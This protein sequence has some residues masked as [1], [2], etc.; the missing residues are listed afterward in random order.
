MSEM[1]DKLLDAVET[2]EE[3]Q[4]PEAEKRFRVEDDQ[5]AEWCFRIIREANEEIKKWTEFYEDRKAKAIRK[6]EARIAHMEFLLEGYFRDVP[7]DETKTQL[8][9]KLP[10][11]KLVM[12]K[13][14]LVL[15]HD[16]EQ[17]L[18]WL[19]QNRPAFVKTKESVDWAGLKKDLLSDAAVDPAYRGLVTDDGEIIPGISRVEKP[20]EF[21][22][23]V[24]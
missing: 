15:E 2:E 8:S 21:K 13:P 17:L 3:I 5:G 7:K 1:I 12:K 20:A 18:P 23:E 4:I 10:G 14:A 11:G 19:K 22:V 6:Q 9:Y 24:K 16:D